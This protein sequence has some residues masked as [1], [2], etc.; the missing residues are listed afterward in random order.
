MKSIKKI[1]SYIVFV[2]SFF[3]I[4]RPI[5]YSERFSVFNDDIKREI[6]IQEESIFDDA[7]D[8]A[9]DTIEL[10]PSLDCINSDISYVNPIV[11]GQLSIVER[12][13]EIFYK[14]VILDYYSSLED[15][16]KNAF[17]SLATTSDDILNLVNLMNNNFTYTSL[18]AGID[19]YLTRL[20]T[21]EV[22][23]I[24]GDFIDTV[25][26]YGTPV[27]QN[28]DE[29]HIP[30]IGG[31]FGDVSSPYV[32]GV[33]L[34]TTTL[35]NVGLASYI[36]A[37][38]KGSYIAMINAVISALP[39]F[40]KVALIAAAIVIITVIII[41]HWKQIKIIFSVMVY[42]FLQSASS[43]VNKVAS[44]F[45]SIELQ[46]KQSE[47]DNKVKIDNEVLYLTACK[48][49]DKVPQDSN[50]YKAYLFLNKMNVNK[51]NSITE[52]NSVTPY[53]KELS[54]YFLYIDLINPIDS[55]TAANWLCSGRDIPMICN[56]YTFGQGD[57]FYVIQQ[58]FQNSEITNPEI[59]KSQGRAAFF[60][61][62]ALKDAYNNR[63]EPHSFYG[64][65]FNAN[66]VVIESENQIV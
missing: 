26:F 12:D 38:L 56:T 55:N 62:H 50:Y 11:D 19:Y 63:Y 1:V 30:E 5:A 13:D 34:L 36:I 21:S 35:A 52:H 64:V 49:M 6:S 22:R 37:A 53:D 9:R 54:K 25:L 17:F 47:A 16:V 39:T 8:E 20:E 65:P 44:I 59:H 2:S 28:G 61:F 7:I 32:A 58:A 18:R 24:N 43:F 29:Q 10:L 27:I 40:I 66:N 14:R 31:D 60:H 42:L 48:T 4:C 45:S 15:D 51:S 57:A 41:T 23:E 3:L 46:A 33:A